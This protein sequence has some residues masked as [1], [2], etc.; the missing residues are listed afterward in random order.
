MTLETCYTY[1]ASV[2]TLYELLIDLDFLRR[3]YESLGAQTINVTEYGQEGDIFLIAWLRDMPAGASV[4]RWDEMIEWSRTENGMHAD[5][6][7]RI[8]GTKETLAG[9]FDLLA[10]GAGCRLEITLEASRL[11]AMTDTDLRQM[12]AHKDALIR[13][14][15]AEILSA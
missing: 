5:Y 13:Q 8:K 3:K 12:L 6:L 14:Y 10:E 7:G 1:D 11:Q 4:R 2:Q 9:E 15:L